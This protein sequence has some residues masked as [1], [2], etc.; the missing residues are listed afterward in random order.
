MIHPASFRP[1]DWLRFVQIDPFPRMW[2]SLKLSDDDLRVLEVAIMSLPE[3]PPVIS[4]AKGLRKLRFSK[5]ESDQGKSGSYRIYYVYFPEYATVLLMAI[6]AKNVQSD[7]NKA[8]LNALSQVVT[9]FKH[10]LDQG[11]IK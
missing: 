4:G 9:R 11:A 7:L 5:A 2:S 6:I 3:R 10:L 1:Q 8:D